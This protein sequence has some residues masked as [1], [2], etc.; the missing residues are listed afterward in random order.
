M[1][2]HTSMHTV[3][4]THTP[5]HTH[6]HSLIHKHTLQINRP[7][8]AHTHTLK[9]AHTFIHAHTHTHSHAHTHTDT[10]SHAQTPTFT[11][12]SPWT[13]H[14]EGVGGGPD[15]GGGVG[16]QL[17]PGSLLVDEVGQ[18]H[19]VLALAW[20]A[21]PSRRQVEHGMRQRPVEQISTHADLSESALESDRNRNS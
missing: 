5:I 14:K 12:V 21:G 2:I 13:W 4:H 19:V 18:P 10:P 17:G 16:D 6:T 8:Q 11:L 9:H 7:M 15:E 20:G 3:T 1:N